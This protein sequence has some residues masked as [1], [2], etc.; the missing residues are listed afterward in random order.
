MG[1]C[2]LLDFVSTSTIEEFEY[3]SGT[4]YG[5]SMVAAI[6]LLHCLLFAI[7]NVVQT[8]NIMI[9]WIS[10]S[11]PFQNGWGSPVRSQ[12]Y[13]TLIIYCIKQFAIR[14]ISDIEIN[15]I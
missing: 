11:I 14:G 3:S 5:P 15:E 2:K 4:H 8:S 1:P 7:E 6:D 9:Q 10:P 13:M 12:P